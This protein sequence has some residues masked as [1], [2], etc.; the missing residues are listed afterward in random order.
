MKTIYALLLS[1]CATTAP[2]SAAVCQ[3]RADFPVDRTAIVSIAAQNNALADDVRSQFVTACSS[4][5]DNDIGEIEKNLLGIAAA[6]G[7]AQEKKP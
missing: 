2:T 5:I 6:D 1:G 4:Q 3:A 7:G